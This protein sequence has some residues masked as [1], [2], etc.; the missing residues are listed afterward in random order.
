VTESRTL[1]LA[2]WGAILLPLAGCTLPYVEQGPAP[3]RYPRA[4]SVRDRA[5]QQID[6]IEW[7]VRKGDLDED[8]ADALADNDDTVL[9][10]A[11]YY[12]D[13]FNPPR[14][15]TRRESDRLHFLLDDNQALLE[16]ALR[17]RKAWRWFFNRGFTSYPSDPADR[18]IYGVCLHYQ[19]KVQYYQVQSQE[20]SGKIGTN[21]AREMKTR[22]TR[23]RERRLEAIR[24]GEPL[25]L[26]RQGALQLE[27]M[28]KDNS[29]LLKEREKGSESAWKGDRSEGWGSPSPVGTK[30]V[31]REE[32]WRN[33]EL[34]VRK[35]AKKGWERLED[36]D[37]PAP[38][39]VPAIR[40][41]PTPLPDLR[42]T[43][44]DHKGTDP[45][46]RARREDRGRRERGGP[47][48]GDREKDPTPVPAVRPSPTPLPDLREA[49]EDH[50]GTDFRGRSRRE[51]RGRRERGSPSMGDRQKDPAVQDQLTP[52]GSTGEAGP[53]TVKD[54][55][56]DKPKRDLR[57]PGQGRKKRSPEGLRDQREDPRGVRT[58]EV[59]PEGTMTPEADEADRDPSEDEGH[60]KD[61]RGGRGR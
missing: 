60:K 45:R 40:P 36:E 29:R 34:R 11:N 16:D 59:E 31:Y 35:G 5:F 38:T 51:D 15:L 49:D 28:V 21:T 19:V 54:G 18:R 53:G 20:R 3:I 55:T 52:S 33:D 56:E 39:P 6:S 24:S 46:G 58:K 4:E 9:E 2:L 42:E 27:G 43:D 1:W 23:I 12:Q 26:D 30:K 10:L 44:E 25:S 61:R 50:K 41:S 47:L 7:S 37:A 8:I 48:V 17:R 14:D 57:G 22:I 13:S 32:R